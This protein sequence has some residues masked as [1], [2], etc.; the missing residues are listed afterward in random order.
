MRVEQDFEVII[1]WLTKNV[2]PKIKDDWVSIIGEGWGVSA[3]TDY[4][5]KGHLIKDYWTVI[6]SDKKKE[7]IFALTFC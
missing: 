3:G 1:N 7:M 6:I 4:N 5:P 2:G